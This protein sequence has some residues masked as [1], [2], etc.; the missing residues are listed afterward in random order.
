MKNECSIVG[1]LLALWMDGLVSEDTAAF[2][3]E[4]LDRCPAC[5]ARMEQL[6]APAAPQAAAQEER[7]FRAFAARWKKKRRRALAA[8]A[9]LALAAALLA[10]CLFSAAAFGTANFVSAAAGLARITLLNEPWAEI[11]REP[12]VVLAAPE[13]D[14]TDYM[15]ARGFAENEQERMGALRVFEK[16]GAKEYVLCSVNRWFARWVW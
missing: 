5:R 12:K 4:H 8:F 11:A 9:A 15:A 2:V 6:R 10:A 3:E 13:T 7:A 14:L 16:G 1:D